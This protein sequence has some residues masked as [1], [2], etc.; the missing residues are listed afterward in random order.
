MSRTPGQK[1]VDLIARDLGKHE[2]PPGS[3]WGPYVKR[4]LGSAGW[5]VPAPWCCALATQV[6]NKRHAL[7][8]QHVI[9]VPAT[10]SC[11]ALRTWAQAHGLWLSAAEVKKHPERLKS[12]YIGIVKKDEHAVVVDEAHV[13]ELRVEDISGN[14]STSDG[15]NYNGGNVA[16]HEH[17]IDVFSGFVKTWR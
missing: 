3:N 15:S 11:Y 1:I 17:G 10:A 13:H 9:K 14:T 2:S 8:P 12:G 6:V 5:T 4:V 7:D 16:R